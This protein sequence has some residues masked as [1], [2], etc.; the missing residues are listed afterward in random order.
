VTTFTALSYAE[1]ASAIPQNGGG[2]TYV[3]EE[4]SAP[5]SFV[6]GWTRW[7]TYMIAGSL[8]ALGFASNSVEFGHL[9]DVD[10]P[11]P[12]VGCALVAVAI[13]VESDVADEVVNLMRD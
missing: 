3:R 5:V 9:Y 8:Y 2:Y 4:F 10:L 6:M 13:A 11:A 1:L 12:G 7:F